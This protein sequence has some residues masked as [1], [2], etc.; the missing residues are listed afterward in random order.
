[1]QTSS[2][3]S[4][5]HTRWM[6]F[7]IVV[8]VTLLLPWRST[9]A[10]ERPPS[11]GSVRQ[12]YFYR[13]SGESIQELKA[14]SDILFFGL[15]DGE[16]VRKLRANGY[17]RPIMTYLLA[18]ELEGPANA[19]SASSACSTNVSPWRNNL[20][21]EAGVFCREIHPN[22]DW[23]LHN[24]KG[25]R[26]YATQSGRG[27]THT[28]YYMNPGNPGLRAWM[29]QRMAQALQPDGDVFN[30]VFLD[31][32][33]LS[34]EKVE[35]ELK[36]SDGKTQE[37]ADDAGYRSAWVGYLKQLSD[38]LRPGKQIWGNMIAD[39]Y[40]GSA[41]DAYMDYLD[42][43]LAEAFAAGWPR[44]RFSPARWE[45]HMQQISKVLARG[46]A[47]VGVTQGEKG[48]NGLMD[49]GVGCY[50]LV[51][52]GERTFFRYSQ[53][54]D[55]GNWYQSQSFEYDLG[56]PLGERFQQ[57]DGTWRRN[58]EQGYVVVDPK[59]RTAEI[60]TG[61]SGT[62]P[63]GPSQPTSVVSRIYVPI[64]GRSEQAPTAIPDTS[65]VETTTDT[66]TTDITPNTAEPNTDSETPPVWDEDTVTLL[67]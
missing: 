62:N 64:A 35:R 23:F 41:W 17:T 52:Q 25:Q 2:T 34:L 53:Y 21:Y 40:D 66:T 24:S 50:L 42:G 65:A 19:T 46:K 4:R 61:S 18:A 49:F 60:K 10:D 44:S 3:L 38:T 39:P 28:F 27:G 36:L 56:N 47:V 22:E 13:P 30:G 54:A 1:M 11:V 37:Y 9:L 55:Y 45:R 33:E 8:L 16:A 31:N 59:N 14:N 67:P 6:M 26:L 15:Q 43:G 57:R 51:A 32:V 20:A 29:A 12:A 7:L 5:I 63:A 58:F 48:S